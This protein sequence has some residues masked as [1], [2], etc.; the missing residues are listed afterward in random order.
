MSRTLEKDLDDFISRVIGNVWFVKD[1]LEYV[2]QHEGVRNRARSII[3]IL[4]VLHR[5][6]PRRVPFSQR[7][8]LDNYLGAVQR[9]LTGYD[10]LSV[11]LS[12]KAMEVAFL[13]K[14]EALSEE[15]KKRFRY[16]SLDGLRRILVS[17]GL[18]KDI[19]ANEIV[20]RI[21][22]RRNMCV[23]DAILEQVMARVE[24]EWLQRKL[25]QLPKPVKS[26]MQRVIASKFRFLNSLPDLSWYVTKRSLNASRKL[27]FDFLDEL[28]GGDLAPIAEKIGFS[29][30][31]K[32]YEKIK[33][34]LISGKLDYLKRAAKEN[35]ND[36]YTV[37]DNLYDGSIFKFV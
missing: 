20:P 13:F 4:K 9:Y 21:I 28:I 7:L 16:R 14:V 35:L 36:V 23:H 34:T 30:F 5:Y 19:L 15:E 3:S 10:L 37:L 26:L 11:H 24:T 18:L 25:S 22:T 29:S 17:R 27:I 32:L 6:K 2:L 8:I 31:Q 12:S 1:N 33:T